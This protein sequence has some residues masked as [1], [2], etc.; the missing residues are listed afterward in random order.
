MAKNNLGRTFF[1]KQCETGLILSKKVL[2]FK[3]SHIWQ[4]IAMLVFCIIFVAYLQELLLS[5]KNGNLR[6]KL[7]IEGNDFFVKHVKLEILPKPI[8]L[9]KMNHIQQFLDF[10]VFWSFLAGNWQKKQ[11][12]FHSKK[13]RSRKEAKNYSERTFFPQ[14][15]VNRVGPILSETVLNFQKSHIVQFIAMQV[16]CIVFVAHSPELQ[17][18][19][20]HV[21][22]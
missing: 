6:N 20:M 9:F 22:H 3:T 11:L 19:C 10:Q 17:L 16:F 15:V 13:K 5:G 2:N 21:N 7:R 18:S 4:F 8:L 12:S 1:L 14:K